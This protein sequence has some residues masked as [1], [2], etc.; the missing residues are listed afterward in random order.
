MAK[1]SK[2]FRQ[3]L[4]RN[5]TSVSRSQKSLQQF[6]K[7]FEQGAYGDNVSGFMHNPKGQVKMSDVLKAF[8]KPYLKEMD[9]Y[10][11]QHMFLQFA[12][13]AWNIASMPEEKRQAAKEGVLREAAKGSPNFVQQDL[14]SLIDELIE[15]KLELFPNNRR[16]IVDFQ[17]ED[18]G[19]EYHLSVASTPEASS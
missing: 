5:Q 11:E 6:E 16:F 15:R 4:R 2:G 14:N 3:L 9:S 10:D 7:R 1:K 19:D 8:A 13:I 18:A 17:F 12:V